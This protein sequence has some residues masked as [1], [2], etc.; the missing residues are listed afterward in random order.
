MILDGGS[1]IAWGV[2]KA[3][4]AYC[5]RRSRAKGTIKGGREGCRGVDN[6]RSIWLPSF[7]WYYVP[8]MS[9]VHLS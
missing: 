1:I 4:V 5:Y 3:F 8:L 7:Y 9:H 6:N 2:F